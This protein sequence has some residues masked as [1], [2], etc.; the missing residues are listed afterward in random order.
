MKDG[1]EKPALEESETRKASIRARVEHPFRVIKRQFGLLKVRFR[2]LAR[3]R[4]TSSRYSRCRTCGWPAGD[5]W[6]WQGYFVRRLRNEENR[7]FESNDKCQIS[8]SPCAEVSAV[9]A[10][11]PVL[12]RRR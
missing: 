4:H 1:R 7:R 8:A 6:R 5:C 10:A 3:T 9:H 11:A 12:A 2:G